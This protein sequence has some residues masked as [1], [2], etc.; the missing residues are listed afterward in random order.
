MRI[1]YD[2]Q[3]LGDFDDGQLDECVIG[4]GQLK[5]MD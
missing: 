2:T 3:A 5:Q 1:A 4:L